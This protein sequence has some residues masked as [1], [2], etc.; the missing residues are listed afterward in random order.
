MKIKFFL[1][2]AL[3]LFVSVAQAQSV[4]EIM[5]LSSSYAGLSTS[6]VVSM[7]GAFTSLGAD[8][9][10][11]DINPAGLGMYRSN[12]FS[13]TPSLNMISATTNSID[14]SGSVISNKTNT[15]KFNLAN[16]A[17]I[18]TFPR[19]RENTVRS[20]SLGFS[21]NRSADFDMH[22]FSSSAPSNGSISDYFSLQLKGVN[23]N[24]IDIEQHKD[25]PNYV[26]NYP[27][28]MW[29]AIMNYNNWMIDGTDKEP[30]EYNIN[31][32]NLE[33]NDFVTPTQDVL[34]SG[35]S[36][37]F[38]ISTGFN[39]KDW[40][41][42]GVT[43][44][45]R[46]FNYTESVLYQEFGVQGNKGEFKELYYNRHTDMSGGSFDFKIGA[47]AQPITGLR[48]GL[49]YHA[50][51][52][53][54]VDEEYYEDQDVSY[55]GDKNN[56]RYQNSPYAINRY[57]VVSS[58]KLLTG[59]SY[60]LGNIGIIAF[61]YCLNLNNSVKVKDIDGASEL[62]KDIR[63]AT[64]NNSEYKVGLEIN[65]Y[66]GL[67]ARGGFNYIESYYDY[68]DKGN[69]KYGATRNL[70]VGLGY[71]SRSFFVDVAYQHSHYLIEPYYY[72]GGSIDG[73]SVISES[74]IDSKINNNF[75]TMTVGFKF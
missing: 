64:R 51:K 73:T 14:K 3:T 11:I 57:K 22:S 20:I 60:R 19:S 29:G 13:V 55:N 33:I 45:G 8:A 25:T 12:E 38:S 21:Y 65:V 26:Y 1:V 75:V 58:H 63:Q 28:N 54:W 23:P 41:Y 37:N 67:F 46:S 30:Y 18:F 6:R 44:G 9:G 7:G 56:F 62:S 43:M 61:D 39:I 4:E 72:Y 35:Q 42:L 66:R 31:P 24:S 74:V 69:N 32:K 70:S 34:R 40:L 59:I 36:N 53:T 15:T 17:A 2:A 49:A 50:P 48:I 27:I 10:S 47:T 68:E 16:M 52:V 71:K 5:R